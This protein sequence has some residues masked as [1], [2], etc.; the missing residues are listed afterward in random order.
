L[1]FRPGNA[2]EGGAVTIEL[3]NCKTALLILIPIAIAAEKRR[4]WYMGA[5]TVVMTKLVIFGA[6]GRWEWRRGELVRSQNMAVLGDLCA[7]SGVRSA[8]RRPADPEPHALLLPLFCCSA[9]MLTN[10]VPR[11]A[12]PLIVTSTGSGTA[13]DHGERRKVR[14]RGRREG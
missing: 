6:R 12:F 11:D 2:S 1:A 13:G 4:G 14:D 9:N 7:F 8:L 5:S 3:K 10:I